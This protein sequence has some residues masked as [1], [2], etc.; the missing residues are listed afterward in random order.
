MQANRFLSCGKL[1]GLVEMPVQPLV[2]VQKA[3]SECDI[4]FLATAHE[5][6]HD[7]APVFLAQG[8]PIWRYRVKADDTI[9]LSTALNIS[10]KTGWT[11][12]C[13]ALPS[14][15]QKRLKARS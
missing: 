6:S 4:V 5:V 14:G 1:A 7:L 2:D 3:A 10:T 12:R 9:P 13:M 15:T 8:G 11:R